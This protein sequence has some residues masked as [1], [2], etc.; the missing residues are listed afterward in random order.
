ME[1]C[2]FC[3]NCL[4]LT[5]LNN[6]ISELIVSLVLEL[7]SEMGGAEKISEV[8]YKHMRGLVFRFVSFCKSGVPVYSVLQIITAVF[9][10]L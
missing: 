3:V 5:V 10:I 4:D 6:R 7:M 8:F 1:L 2:N 9:H